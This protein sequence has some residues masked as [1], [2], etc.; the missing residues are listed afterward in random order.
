MER[1]ESWIRAWGRVNQV[2]ALGFISY[3]DPLEDFEQRS[4]RI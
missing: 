4:D 3:G 1:L 2:W